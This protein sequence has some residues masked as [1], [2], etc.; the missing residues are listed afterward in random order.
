MTTPTTTETLPAP[1][2]RY[3]A[4]TNA[5]DLEGIMATFADDALVNDHR[6]EFPDR[7]AI[8][9]WAAREIVADRVTMDVV[10][11]KRRGH[12]VAVRARIDGNFDKKGL[13]SPLFLDFYFSCSATHIE[14]LVIVF[15]TPAK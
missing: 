12:S 15:N 6:C 11:G 8:R 13:P 7:A 3:I 9:G 2:A 1:V 14:Q 4:A 5:F 10:A